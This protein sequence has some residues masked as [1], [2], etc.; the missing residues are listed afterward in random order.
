MLIYHLIHFSQI[1]WMID[2]LID[3]L[4]FIY[5]F[6]SFGWWRNVSNLNQY[7]ISLQISYVIHIYNVFSI[8]QD[9]FI[10]KKT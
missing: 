2:W 3:L 6:N 7:I 8:K 1:D 9:T 5:L 4:L 10:I